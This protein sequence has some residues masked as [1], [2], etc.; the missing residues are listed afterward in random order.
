MDLVE[1]LLE[2][3]AAELADRMEQIVPE[4]VYPL[5]RAAQLLGNDSQRAGK[6]LTEWPP[7]LLPIVP[8]T[9]GG[10]K[11]GVYGRDL[12]RLIRELRG[13]NAPELEKVG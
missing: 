5:D 6:T 2:R 13:P 4:R 8:I 9:P 1:R 10:G 3:T 11:L 12:I 7:E